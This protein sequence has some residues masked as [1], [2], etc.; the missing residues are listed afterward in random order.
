MG[1]VTISLGEEYEKKLRELSHKKYNS[2]K[3][4]MGKIMEEGI[5]LVEKRERS[6]EA[7]ERQLKTMKKGFYLG[8]KRFQRAEAYER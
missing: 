5:E 6:K 3:G 4:A 2:R 7:W 8:I 1:T